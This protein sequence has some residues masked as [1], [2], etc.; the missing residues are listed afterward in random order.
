MKYQ[1]NLQGVKLGVSRIYSYITRFIRS[2]KTVAI[3]FFVALLLIISFAVKSSYS[4]GSC[5]KQA[6]ISFIDESGGRDYQFRA[7]TTSE[8][9][10]FKTYVTNIS[11]YFL[12]KFDEIAQC[13]G[14]LNSDPQIDL[15]FVY[16][17]MY[18]IRERTAPFDFERT[19]ARNT[20]YLD[21]P[22]VKLTITRSPKLIVKAA[23]FWNER[24]FPF[25]QAVLSGAS[26]SPTAPLLPLDHSTYMKFRGEYTSKH[27]ATLSESHEIRAAVFANLA[28]R[29]P[30]DLMWLFSHSRNFD[31]NLLDEWAMNK[32]I[33]QQVEPYIKLTKELLNR[34]FESMQIEQ[35]YSSILDLKDVFDLDKYRIDEIRYH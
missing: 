18:L 33:E 8:N 21:S 7:V 2:H 15:A 16:R 30:A 12:V 28:N 23:F 24:Q 6:S 20:K 29:L 17:P 4:D 11:K 35:R 22:W 32:A 25:D 19:Q 5:Q 1:N 14:N 31:G 26:P 13:Q 3:A 27:E 9:S 10:F 34:R